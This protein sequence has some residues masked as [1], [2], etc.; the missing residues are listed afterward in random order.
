MYASAVVIDLPI[1]LASVEGSA[2]HR[3]SQKV[4]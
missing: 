1:Q 3:T 2:Q 4:A